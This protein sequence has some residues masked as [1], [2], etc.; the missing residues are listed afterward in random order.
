MSTPRIMQA[1]V[2]QGFAL[3]PT[4][5]NM[6]VND[7]PHAI[8]VH[9]ALFADYTCHYATKRKEGSV[10][11]KLQ[12]GLN[13]VAEWSKRWNIKINED[14]TQAIYFSHRIRPPE[15]LLTL[16]E[17]NIPFVNNVNYP[18]VTFDKKI[19]WRSHMEMIEAKTFRAFITT[20]TLF[21]SKQL[22][23][24][25]KLTL[26]KALIRSVMI[27]ACPAWEFA[28][29]THLLKLQ[30][31]QNKVLRTIGNF[32][33]HTPV[34]E[35]HKTKLCRKQAKIIQNHVIANRDIENLRGL[36]LVV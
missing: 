4:L 27:Y 11:R 12:R 1:G 36:N 2:P 22:N 10:L 25:I 8:G 15:S 17:R 23:T 35:L 28:A 21:K 16:N 32:P 14:K 34:C 3:S 33:R 26:H 7:T 6:Y 5:F 29:D 19:T 13:S 18:G 20:Y 31:L 9:L 30:R 24:N